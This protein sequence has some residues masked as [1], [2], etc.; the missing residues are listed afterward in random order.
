M[1]A[2]KIVNNLTPKELLVV[3]P[4]AGEII[5]RNLRERISGKNQLVKEIKEKLNSVKHLPEMDHFFCKELIVVT[6]GNELVEIEKKHSSSA[7]FTK[8][9]QRPCQLLSDK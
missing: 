1:I 8:Y 4:E 6:L 7:K 9:N 5:E 2:K 3:F